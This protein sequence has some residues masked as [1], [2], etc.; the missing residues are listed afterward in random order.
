MRK[1]PSL[2]SCLLL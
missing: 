2:S 1:V